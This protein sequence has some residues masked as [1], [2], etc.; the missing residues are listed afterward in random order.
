MLIRKEDYEGKYFYPKCSARQA[1]LNGKG[2]GGLL[3]QN[4][5]KLGME[6]WCSQSLSPGTGITTEWTTPIKH[7]EKLADEF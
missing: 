1:G 2:R 3:E 5:F 6:T 4:R 7:R